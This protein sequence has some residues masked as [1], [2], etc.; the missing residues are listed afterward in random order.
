[1]RQTCG[2]RFHQSDD[3][4]HVQLAVV[5]VFGLAH[6][7]N[8]MTEVESVDWRLLYAD[9]SS[10][11]KMPDDSL[12]RFLRD[13]VWHREEESGWSQ[14]PFEIAHIGS[15]RVT[16]SEQRQL[17]HEPDVLMK[18]FS[19]V[20]H[21][22]ANGHLHLDPHDPTPSIHRNEVL[23]ELFDEH[24]SVLTDEPQIT[25]N[26]SFHISRIHVLDGST[27]VPEP[28]QRRQSTASPIVVEFLE[29]MGLGLLT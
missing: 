5:N 4:L 13:L 18:A 28:L 9:Q 2:L 10:P 25:G 11:G 24:Q 22:V 21:Q 23:V 27:I 7:R 16:A 1:M 17:P 12:V 20:V 6:N 26:L 14:L 8:A 29:D 19:P 3:S 15:L